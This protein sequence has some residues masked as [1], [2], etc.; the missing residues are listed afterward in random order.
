MRK[1]SPTQIV[2]STTNNSTGGF[3]G[4]HRTLGSKDDII[5][6]IIID[7]AGRAA[8]ELIFGAKF[9]TTGAGSDYLNA[10][11]RLVDMYRK[12]GLGSA[13]A[14]YETNA[15]NKMLIDTNASLDAAMEHEANRL[16]QESKKLLA[17]NMDF[18]LEI[19]N[20]LFTHK[21]IDV[22]E[23]IL[24]ANKYV[25][26]FEHLPTGQRYEVQYEDMLKKALSDN[27]S[28]AKFKS[29]IN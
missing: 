9:I 21:K 8:E 11:S 29:I 10:T 5:N 22:E 26:G 18:L 4:T 6:N 28:K 20:E 12:S 2:A 19:S 1:C 25:V 15:N 3:V 16:Y 27:K 7:Y 13:T 23:F 17:A 14:V 24:I